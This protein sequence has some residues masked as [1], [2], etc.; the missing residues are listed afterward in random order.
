MFKF[1]RGVDVKDK[2]PPAR[3]KQVDA[4]EHLLHRPRVW[5]RIDT[6]QRTDCRVHRAK[7]VKL[8]HVLAQQQRVGARL[9]PCN[10]QHLGRDIHADDLPPLL[11]KRQQIPRSAAQVEHNLR[12]LP[13][14]P[15]NGLVKLRHGGI[16]RP[17]K[18]VVALR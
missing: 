17:H 12:V 2:Q 11:Q 3:Q 5:Q 16:I 15:P 18:G 6:V 1:I 4:G 13:K 14:L 8:G 7:Q 9:F 10:C